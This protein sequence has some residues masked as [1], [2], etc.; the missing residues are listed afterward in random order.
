MET[1]A[2]E[3]CQAV[4]AMVI[5]VLS[6]ERA[7]LHIPVSAL[8][9]YDLLHVDLALKLDLANAYLLTLPRS[10]SEEMFDGYVKD[11]SGCVGSLGL[12]VSRDD[13]VDRLDAQPIFAMID[14]GTMKCKEEWASR[15]TTECFADFCRSLGGNDPLY[16]QK[17]YT[18]LG[19]E[20]ASESPRGNLPIWPA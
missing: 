14:P 4:V 3:E 5:R 6:A 7:S 2:F 10:D 12:Q 1:M 11:S 9:G 20:Y 8:E 19:L 18:R 13:E 15:E 16:W 17:V